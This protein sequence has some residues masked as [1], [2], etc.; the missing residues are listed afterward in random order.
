MADLPDSRPPGYDRAGARRAGG[1]PAAGRS[2]G[3]K[4]DVETPL[5][6]VRPRVLA[7]G[8]RDGEAVLLE[9]ALERRLERRELGVL[10]LAGPSGA[11]KRTALEFVR[12]RFAD[13]P[14]VVTGERWVPGTVL[15]VVTSARGS[16]GQPRDHVLELAPWTRDEW[17]EYLLA[18]HPRACAGVMAR[19]EQPERHLALHGN[20]RAWS[21]LLDALALDPAL[22]DDLGALAAAVRRHFSCAEAHARAR[23]L[24]LRGLVAPASTPAAEL[25]RLAQAEPRAAPLL[26]LASVRLLLSAE[27]LVQS[28]VDARFAAELP[29]ACAPPLLRVVGPLLRAEPRAQETLERALVHPPRELQ[30][31]AASLLHRCGPHALTTRLV[32]RERG[33]PLPHLAAAQLP[34]LEAPGLDLAG[35]DLAHANLQ[36]A[37]LDGTNLG[38]A[39]LAS[40]DLSRA[41]L[42]GVRL[43]DAHAARAML[44][45][46]DL[47]ATA[48]DRI[49][50]RDAQLG[51]ARF[52]DASL[53][54]ARLDGADLQGALFDR[55]DLRAAVLRGARV[56]RASF[57]ATD[58]SGAVLDSVDLRAAHLATRLLAGA[59]LAGSHLEGLTLEAPDL[60]GAN[61]AQALLTA[62]RL[63]GANL[64][65]ACLAGAGLA[66][67]EWPGADLREADLTHASFHLGSSR[68]GLLP[69]AP[70]S[71]GTRTG[72]YT[73]EARELGFQAPE[74]IRKADL[75]GA[76]L[77]GAR[78]RDADFYLVDLR[79]A[80][81]TPDQAQHLRACGAIL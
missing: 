48:L 20:A 63:P 12:Q 52:E 67:V 51:E 29:R 8:R 37:R 6:L 50:L 18:N 17:I 1:G 15:R 78:I 76:D 80:L 42:R 24:L 70:V 44:Q 73:D 58:L 47:R 40:C 38:G 23:A 59:S 19:L 62:T 66:Q 43:T 31:S 54:Q 77:R 21:A 10:V 61:L 16:V 7:P 30:A 39:R 2:E 32:L 34:G 27:G 49:D 72:F 5:R 22:P 45:G 36:G 65:G 3:G 68:S 13:R 25:Q 60:S 46:A 64:R 57:V 14:E 71:W 33:L 53:R 4:M 75:R 69:A 26:A 74:A 11:G 28:L 9:D 55:A 56:A 79:G 35:V 81:Y 41:S